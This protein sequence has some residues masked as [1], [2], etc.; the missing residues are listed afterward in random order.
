MHQS[1][2]VNEINQIHNNVNEITTVLNSITKIA[3]QTTILGINASIEAAHIGNVGKG[4]AVVAGE[5]R[6]LSD[7]TKDTVDSVGRI[8]QSI[9]ESINTTMKSAEKTLETTSNQSAAM[10][11]L[12]ATVQQSVALAEKLCEFIDNK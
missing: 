1:E 8:N 10:E 7:S 5:I 3:N 4:F 12:A 6:K 2:L 11:E 9:E